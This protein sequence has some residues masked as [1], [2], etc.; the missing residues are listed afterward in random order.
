MSPNQL[1]L[2]GFETPF[3]QKLTWRN[4]WVK[5]AHNIPWDKLVKYYDDLF[6]SK[7]GRPPISGRVILG[8]VIIKHLGDL[9]DRETIAQIQE[10]MFMQY[11]LGY[12]SFTNEEP[13]SDTL[14]PEIRERLSIELLSRINEVIALHCIEMHEAKQRDKEDLFNKKQKKTFV[15][16]NNDSNAP[17]EIDAAEIKVEPVESNG[18]SVENNVEQKEEPP[19]AK[20]N[21]GK[22]L[23]DA[24]VAPQNITFP[25]D[26][27]LLNAARKKSEELIDILYDH[28]LHGK[29][30]VRT[31]RQ[32]AR[33][34]FLNSAK[35]KRKT[36]KEIYKANGSQL[37]YLRRN[38]DHI[39]F[40]LA[41]YKKFPLKP[42]DQ[43]YLMV[44]HTVYDQQEEMHR[45]HTHRID[46]RIVNIHQPHV[47]PIVRGKENAKTEF[48]SKVQMSLVGG[49]A[50]ID[51][52]S[53]EAFNEGGYLMDSVE[54][55]KA[56]FGFYPAEVLADQIYC[57][58]DNRKQL[59]LL[60]IKLIARPLGR[61]S[62][63][64]MK[65]HLSP[66]E[67]NPIEGKFGQAKVAY[68]LNNIRAKLSSTSTSWIA[69]IAL[70]L[71]LVKLTGQALV[72]LLLLLKNIL[73][74]LSG[75]ITNISYNYNMI[76]SAPASL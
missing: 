17:N 64:A 59:K 75:E 21:K 24:T 47:R 5:L 52:L 68:G 65:I 39:D 7:E 11:F 10:N 45:T 50:F 26:L 48:G 42:K 36:A 62:A 73:K 30:K 23:M 18:V 66:G 53:W 74:N 8:A 56:R 57:T 44:L 72:S 28:L 19:A 70:V 63:Q 49:F 35:K 41:A 34:C 12:S 31:Y 4:R 58:R 76:K 54:K 60:D 37:R 27:K 40:L 25:T 38:L 3:E 16:N 43:K 13:F 1:V 69:A 9:T 6:P 32:E 2:P 61:P 20:N 15:Q 14:F 46:H 33:K 22:L 67:R 51:H 71:N 55:Y 29:I